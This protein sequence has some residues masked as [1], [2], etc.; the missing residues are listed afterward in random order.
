MDRISSTDGVP[1][2]PLVTPRPP[3][4]REERRRRQEEEREHQEQSEEEQ[5]APESV[6]RPSDQPGAESPKGAHIDIQ[7]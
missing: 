6:P 4:Y 7:I 3:G 1:Y 2:A 5:T